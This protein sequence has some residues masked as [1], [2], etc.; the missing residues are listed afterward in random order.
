MQWSFR[1]GRI[2]GTDIKIHVTF[3]VLV[4]WYGYA[5]YT[6]GGSEAAL[7]AV[8]F[9]LALF[10]C[11][12]LHEFGHILMAR[13]FGVRTPDVLLL[14]IG[15]LARLE[16]MPE[17]P[18][19]ELLVAVA[20]PAVTLGIALAL[21]GA[22]RLVGA[23][24]NSSALD[25]GQPGLPQQV[26]WV[27]VVLLLFNLL[28][29]FPMDGGRMLRA[30]LAMRLGMTRATRIASRI[31]QAGAL[32]LGLWGLGFFARWGLPPSVVLVLIAVFVYLA[33]GAEAASVETRAAG[34]GLTVREM[35]ITHYVTLPVHAT[36]QHA[37]DALL[38]GEQREFPV[39]DNWGRIEGLL[40]REGLIQGLA[41]LGGEASVER[42]MTRGI[43]P[44]ALAL[45]F[46]DALA[47]LG[48]SGLPALP[49]V[50]PAGALVGLLTRDNVADIL[51]LRRAGVPVPPRRG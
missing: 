27:N 33:A 10:T 25:P 37:V 7:N 47:Q 24:L 5:A 51:L 11:V 18:R 16:R 4:A 48:Q 17:D 42:A 45:P 49:V 38:A 20:G 12:L 9:L 43:Q 39:V 40:T 2:G 21:F 50:D 23:P 34:R 36:L 29:I 35:M 1:I 41:Q 13:R 22:L 26:L 31:G 46:E 30:L 19:Q 28:P 14:P 15:G 32:L 8:V 6:E 44:M 3:L